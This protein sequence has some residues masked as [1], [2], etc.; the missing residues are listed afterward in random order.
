MNRSHA[1]PFPNSDLATAEMAVRCKASIANIRQ[2]RPGSDLGFQM[3]VLKP[4]YV[5]P[6]ALGSS[7]LGSGLRMELAILASVRLRLRAQPS[8]ALTP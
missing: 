5:V 7:A 8:T 3:N 1:S 6:S 2:S 4:Y